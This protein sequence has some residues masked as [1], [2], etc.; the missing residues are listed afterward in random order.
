MCIRAF[1]FL[2]KINFIVFI[3]MVLEATNIGFVTI[4]QFFSQEIDEG[5]QLNSPVD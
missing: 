3:I 2:F 1:L 4:Q 5:S